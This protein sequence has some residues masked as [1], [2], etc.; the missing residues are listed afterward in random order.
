MY[1]LLAI[2]LGTSDNNTDNVSHVINNM[3]HFRTKPC[4]DSKIVISYCIQ[5]IVRVIFHLTVKLKQI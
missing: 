2:T 1:I 4:K 5:H 3:F